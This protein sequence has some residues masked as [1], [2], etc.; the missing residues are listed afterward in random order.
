MHELF[1]GLRVCRACN[2]IALRW[3]CSTT[4]MQERSVIDALTFRLE[5]DADTLG[6]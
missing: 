1:R 5:G 4:T 6:P 3:P 2:Y